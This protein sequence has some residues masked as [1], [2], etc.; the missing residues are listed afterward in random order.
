MTKVGVVTFLPHKGVV[1]VEVLLRG[2]DGVGDGGQTVEMLGHAARL[3]HDGEVGDGAGVTSGVYHG[4]TG[5][6]IVTG[7]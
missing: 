4:S 1:G 2:V 3:G 6:H 5:E 7:A